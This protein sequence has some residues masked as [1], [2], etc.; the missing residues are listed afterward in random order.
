[1]AEIKHLYIR[2]DVDESDVVRLRPGMDARVTIDALLGQSFKGKILRI[3]P[4]GKSQNN[5]TVFEVIVKM[6]PAAASVMKLNMTT[7]LKFA[8]V[9]KPNVLVLPAMAIHQRRGRKGVYV[10]REGQIEFQPVTLGLSNGISTIV[11]KGIDAG[12]VI[13]PSPPRKRGKRKGRR[14]KRRGK[15]MRH[16]RR[17]M[18]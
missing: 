9:R 1:M 3:N 18:R 16:M 11:A 4:E 13:L 5:V 8:V 7:N 2:A 14:G 10:L 15:N 12:D 6:D 17:M